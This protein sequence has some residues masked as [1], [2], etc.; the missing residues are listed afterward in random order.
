MTEQLRAALDEDWLTMVLAGL[1]AA[2]EVRYYRT[3]D[4]GE[5][6][7]GIVSPRELAQHILH[8]A[9]AASATD[10]GPSMVDT[11]EVGL[12]RLADYDRGY[13]DGLAARPAVPVTLDVERLRSDLNT[14]IDGVEIGPWARTR[15][16]REHTR[17]VVN[18]VLDDYAAPLT[19]GVER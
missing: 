11:P 4:D 17:S 14:A 2:I 9:L 5:L 6:G 3:T 7:Y 1:P 10:E 15:R 18:G 12:A 19:E 8:A 16:I 13:S